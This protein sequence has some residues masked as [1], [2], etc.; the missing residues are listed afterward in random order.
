MPTREAGPHFQ[1]FIGVLTLPC[2]LNSYIR[3]WP[4]WQL[5]TVFLQTSPIKYK[6]LNINYSTLVMMFNM[7]EIWNSNKSYSKHMR[8]QQKTFTPAKAVAQTTC[9]SMVLEKID[10]GRYGN[11]RILLEGGGRSTNIKGI[12]TSAGC[13]CWEWNYIWAT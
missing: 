9:K 7:Y 4:S 8:W 11:W 1:Q 5:G 3:N 6:D 13:K 2:G 12:Q 10:R